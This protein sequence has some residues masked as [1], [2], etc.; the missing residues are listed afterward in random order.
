MI[1]LRLIAK[2]GPRL[3]ASY[4]MANDDRGIPAL[5]YF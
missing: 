4:P 1:Y 2:P 5:I 3:R